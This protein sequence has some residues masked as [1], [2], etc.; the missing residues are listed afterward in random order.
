MR[1]RDF[2]TLLG[3]A[4]AWPLAAQAQQETRVRRVG[5][6]LSAAETEA[7]YRNYLALFVQKMRQLGWSEDHNLRIDVR[8][9]AG[10]AGLSRTYA[11]QLI[12]LMPDVI[13]TGSTVNLE[14][15]RQATS[16]IPIVF[17]QVAGPDTQGFVSNLRRPGGNITGLSLF[18]FSLGGKWLNLLKEIAPDLKRVAVVYNPARSL[19]SNSSCRCSMRPRRRSASRSSLWRCWPNPISRQP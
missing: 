15:V 5:V 12:G 13:V 4:A 7:E 19:I 9:N 8:W 14:A 1:R 18:E 11:A 16:T 10:D 6:L 2:V 3:G 17:V